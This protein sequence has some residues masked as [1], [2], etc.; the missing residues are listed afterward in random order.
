M[1][2]NDLK[3]IALL[4]R[5]FDTAASLHHVFSWVDENK[6]NVVSSNKGVHDPVDVSDRDYVQKSI[7][8]PWKIQIGLPIQGRVSAKWVLPVAMGLTDSTGKYIGTILISMDI[9]T[10][11]H[12]LRSVVKDTGI[13]FTVYSDTL[14]PLTQN[15]GRAEQLAAGCLQR[16][17]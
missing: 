9:D 13:S 1:D 5:S 8:E 3:G 10:I 11:T 15:P 7:A 4:L 12:D 6:K 16:R 2:P 17:A 14:L